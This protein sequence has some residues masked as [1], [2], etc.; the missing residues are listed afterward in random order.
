MRLAII[1]ILTLAL[2]T[3]LALFPG[4]ADQEMRIEAFGWLLE[5]KQGAFI[6]V[7]LLALCAIWLI[8]R[9][10][11]AL[12]S[13]PGQLWRVLRTGGRK[14]RELALRENIRKL[15]DMRQELTARNLKKAQGVIPDWSLSLLRILATPAA[16]QEPPSADRDAL[17]TALAARVA[18][19]PQA[20]P[21]PDTATRKA[22]LDAW[23]KASPG[24]PLAIARLPDVA[25][26]EADWAVLVR[27]L[28]DAWKKGDR[29]AASI[30]PRLA[31]AYLKL[32]SQQQRENSE[33]AIA[34]LRKAHRLSSDSTEALLA[35]GNAY[36]AKND[37]RAARSLWFTHLGKHDDAVIAQALFGLLKHDAMRAYRKLETEDGLNPACLWL[38]VQLAHAAELTGL[39]HDHM[40][41]LLEKHPSTL[42]WSTLG[43]WHAEDNNW[44]EACRCYR[45]ALELDNS[46]MMG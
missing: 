40:A 2:A 18:T 34:S 21:K 22:H 4:V 24:A 8:Q 12:L 33:D 42:A 11:A 6:V 38:R 13:G 32:A 16:E 14:R 7:G 29:A 35:L 30:K 25:E 19:D 10:L 28:E 1:L 3:V 44:Q 36:I 37:E 39:A 20:K 45:Q 27:F 17:Q 23:L 26:E 5:T 46:K 41:S 31:H 15:I 43:D 9:I